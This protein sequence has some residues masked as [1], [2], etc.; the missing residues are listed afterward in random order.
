M[1]KGPAVPLP[2]ATR[3]GQLDG[4]LMPNHS[5]APKVAACV[6]PAPSTCGS[7]VSFSLWAEGLRFFHHKG[8]THRLEPMAIDKWAG[9]CSGQPIQ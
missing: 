1:N 5:E 3:V 4:L 6:L 2:G 9:S 8:W 7:Q